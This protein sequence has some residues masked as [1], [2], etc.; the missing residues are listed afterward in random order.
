MKWSTNASVTKVFSRDTN[1]Q[2]FDPKGIKY[3]VFLDPRFPP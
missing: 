3:R 2:I 1:M